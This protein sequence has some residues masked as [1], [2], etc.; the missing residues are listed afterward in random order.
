MNAMNGARRSSARWS[1][2]GSTSA[3]RI[4]AR[5]RCTSSPRSTPC[6][7]CEASSRLFE[8]VATGAADGYAP[9]GRRPAG[10]AAA[11][12]AGSRQR[13]RQ[14]A[15]RAQGPVPDGEHRRRPCHVPQA[16]RRATRVRHR[17]RGPQRVRLASGGRRAHRRC[18]LGRGR[19]RRCRDRPAR[20]GRHTHPA[21]RR[22]VGRRRR[23]AASPSPPRRRD[24]RRR[25]RG[26]P[27]RR[28]SCAVGRTG[29]APARRCRAARAESAR[30]QPRSLR[31]AGAKLLA[32]D[33][34]GAA[35]ARRRPAAGRTRSPISP[36]SRQLQLDGLRH[37]VLVDAKSP[38]S[39][40]AYPDKASELVPE[41]CEVHILAGGNDDV[42]AALEALADAVGAPS[43]AATLQPPARARAAHR[44]AHRRRRRARRS[45]H[46]CPKA[47]SCPTRATRPDCSRPG[48]TAGAPPH[49]WLC[50]TGGAI[51]QGLPVALGAAV[52][53]PDRQ[54]HLPRGR[55]QR[56]VHDPV[57]V[58]D[59]PRR[60]R[61]HHDPVQQPLLR[62]A[63]HGAGPG[64]R[65]SRRSVAPGRCST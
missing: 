5:P 16:V 21:C 11:P 20:P 2:A 9:H 64:R 55:R 1:T 8:G 40:F 23:R 27:C 36:S 19:R 59:G 62:R 56:D 61:R 33:V 31:R 43:D 52:A 4:P 18:R 22:L 24:A 41:G 57:V 44:G 35:R 45:A 14:P 28:R 26:R 34:P 53:C 39:F 12:R 30:G 13:P 32:R 29:S 7:R 3:S 37:L 42:V 47:P 6:P 10:D 48:H 54:G 51:G 17:D 49:D 60:P 63:Q 38:V 15:Q 25:R 50:L 65:R 58:D 46:C